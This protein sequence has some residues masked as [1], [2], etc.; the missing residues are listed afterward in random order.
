[1]LFNPH[2]TVYVQRFGV[3]GPGGVPFKDKG[4]P[5]AIINTVV[6]NA[7]PLKMTIPL[8]LFVFPAISIE[9]LTPACL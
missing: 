1:M 6:A 3:F 7:V 9:V 2:S 5:T 8:G 4:H